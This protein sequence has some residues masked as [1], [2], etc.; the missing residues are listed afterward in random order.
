MSSKALHQQ[1]WGRT[2]PQ[3]KKAHGAVRNALRRGALQRGPCEIC[4]TLHGQDGIIVDAHH[5][6]Y[7]Q[8]LDVT[9]LC[10]QHHRQIHADIRAGVWVK[11]ATQ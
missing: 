11:R 4:G 5:E 7:S 1:L 9:W 6:C 8:P 10:R 3:A 2:K